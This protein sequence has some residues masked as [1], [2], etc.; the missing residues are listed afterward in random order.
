MTSIDEQL[1]PRYSR[2]LSDLIAMAF[3]KACEMGSLDAATHLS[4]ALDFEVE[5]SM[6]LRT[7]ERDDGDDRAAVQAR[8][9]FEIQK[10]HKSRGSFN[11]GVAF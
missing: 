4:H 10:A 7:D 5:R 6:R 11:P 3:Y 8:L 2:R 9:E 1:E